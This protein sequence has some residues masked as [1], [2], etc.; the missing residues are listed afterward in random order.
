MTGATFLILTRETLR[1]ILEAAGDEGGPSSRLITCETPVRL[2]R[3]LFPHLENAMAEAGTTYRRG[4]RF[5]AEQ[6]AAAICTLLFLPFIVLMGAGPRTVRCI[7]RDARD[8]WRMLAPERPLPPGYSEERVW[9]V[10]RPTPPG[11][12]RVY[13]GQGA[14]PRVYRHTPPLE[15]G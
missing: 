13:D 12:Y 3:P 15:L 7:L 1:P 5:R 9:P 11:W 4:F 10:D 6:L 8:L 14:L 2:R